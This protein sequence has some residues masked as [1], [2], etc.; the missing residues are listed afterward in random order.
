MA[1]GY[2]LLGKEQLVACHGFQLLIS[3]CGCR[4]IIFK[5]KWE[6]LN[7]SNYELSTEHLIIYYFTVVIAT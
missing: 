6:L 1:E 7:F 3:C 4:E 5:N 2:Y